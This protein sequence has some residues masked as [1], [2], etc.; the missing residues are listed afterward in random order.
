M[1]VL[2]L[3]G[4]GMNP[5]ACLLRDGRID[6]FAE[7]ERFSRVKAAP[8]QFPG[9]SAAWCLGRARLELGDVDRIAFAWDA[10]KYPY[11]MLGALLRPYLR[12]RL[13]ASGRNGG[14][15]RDATF[16]TVVANL[17]QYTPA[18][19]REEIRLGL[20]AQGLRGD[21]PEIEFVPHHLAHAASAYFC[22]AFDEAVVLT[23]DGSGEDVSTQIAIGRGERLEVVESVPIPH[24]LGWFY[25]AFTAYLGFT[26]YRHEGK[27]MGLAGLGHARARDN[28]WPERL[29]RVLRVEDGRYEVDPT[30]TRFGSHTH[31]ERFTD[32]LADFVT[33]FDS[34]LAPLLPGERGDDGA[35]SRCLDPGYVDLA[36]GVQRRL[37]EAVC[38]VAA[39]A[40]RTHG[41]R[42]LCV[43]GGVGL[44][45]KMNGALRSGTAFEHVFVQPSC[46][47]AGAALGAAMVVAQ[48]GGDGVR[49]PLDS[50]C[51][52]PEW[53]PAE[54]R[55]LLDEC[56]LRAQEC[57]D[58]AARA[59]EEL[60]AGRTVGWFQGRMEVG[61]RAL[62]ARSIL[63]DP[64]RTDLQAALNRVKAREA[65]RPFCPSVLDEARGEV[66]QDAAHA[67][68][69]TTA[70]QV[71]PERARELA[72]VVHADGSVRPQTVR[73]DASP[74]YH[75]LLGAFRERTGLPLVVNT[76]FNF[77]GEPIVCT[78][79]EALRCFYSTGIDVLALGDFVLSK[80]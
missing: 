68:F 24:S 55:G 59:A 4:F 27:L 3:F 80:T 40:A 51:L 34:R 20:R 49:N 6:G 5:G 67:P 74:R 9:R 38:A 18:R 29:E 23:L 52:G 17:L 21:V 8:G 60:A 50:A 10:S 2:G 13:R 64:R 73:A 14:R 22:S 44:N 69:M 72:A 41:P 32:A 48:R 61:P 66:L 26:P 25:A 7:E 57:E 70:F 63:A 33:S 78:P 71:R 62:G 53:S 19:L 15:G 79:R 47:D 36:W 30:F 16:A 76:S 28:R 31:A 42:N 75:R 35:T 77:D 43:A 1:N 56:G 11:G 37:E 54:L 12:Y 65:W 45:C 39:R 46:H 58:V